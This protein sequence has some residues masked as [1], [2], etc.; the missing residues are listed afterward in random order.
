MKIKKLVTILSITI[1][2]FATFTIAAQAT[3]VNKYNNTYSASST[4][5]DLDWSVNGT[6]TK[7]TTYSENV[8]SSS[9]YI[10]ANIDV[11]RYSTDTYITGNDNYV[12]GGNKGVSASIARDATNRNKYYVHTSVMKPSA[13]NSY[14]IGANYYRVNQR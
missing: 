3:T 10:E 5:A 4:V 13:S 7:A 8:V 2:V 11:Y 12:T 6:L 14:T 1:I 9:R